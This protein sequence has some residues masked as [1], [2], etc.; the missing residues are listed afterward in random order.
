MD[1]KFDIKSTTIEK[2][3]EIAKDFVDKLIM[4]SI[5]ETGLL[6]KDHIT[7]WRF[8]NQVKMLNKAKDY[9]EKHNIKSK[10]KL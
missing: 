7:M 2:G 8:K 6:V 3:L 10:K 5:E 9:C 4:P 1:N